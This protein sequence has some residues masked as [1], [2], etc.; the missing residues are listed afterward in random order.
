MDV[1]DM[2]LRKLF[3]IWGLSNHFWQGLQAFLGRAR[4]LNSSREDAKSLDK[5]SSAGYM[6]MELVLAELVLVIRSSC[7]NMTRIKVGRPQTFLTRTLPSPQVTNDALNILS[8]ISVFSSQNRFSSQG[9]CIVDRFVHPSFLPPI[10][11][12]ESVQNSAILDLMRPLFPSPLR[13]RSQN[14]AMNKI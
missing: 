12:L 13:M 9:V 2:S 1:S 14:K 7:G 6:N 10:F 4:W 8:L 3:C 5:E 11:V